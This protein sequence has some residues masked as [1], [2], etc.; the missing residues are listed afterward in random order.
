MAL[1]FLTPK[2]MTDLFY[3][4]ENAKLRTRNVFLVDNGTRKSKEMEIEEE[5]EKKVRLEF[6]R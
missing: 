3:L 5:G 1:A 6:G 2:M 4:L